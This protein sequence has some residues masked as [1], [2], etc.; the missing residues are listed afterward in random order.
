M[1]PKKTPFIGGGSQAQKEIEKKEQTD[2]ELSGKVVVR[3]LQMVA[4]QDLPREGHEQQQ[5]CQ[6]THQVDQM[7]Q[8]FDQRM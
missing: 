1:R 2:H 7:E 8:F 5:T 6:H 4:A 3:E